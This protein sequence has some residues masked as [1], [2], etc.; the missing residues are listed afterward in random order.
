MNVENL[1]ESPTYLVEEIKDGFDNFKL[2]DTDIEIQMRPRVGTDYTNFSKRCRVLAAAEGAKYVIGQDVWL[3]HMI[4]NNKINGESI[5]PSLAG[6]NILYCAEHNIMFSGEVI[7]EI[8]SDEWVV[9]QIKKGK[10]TNGDIIIV[11]ADDDS[12]GITVSGALPKGT[13][14]TW[15]TH[16]RQEVYQK[17]VQYWVSHIDEITTINGEVNPKCAYYKIDTFD[18]Y[19][20]TINGLLFSG[21]AAKLRE[22]KL[23][24]LPVKHFIARL[25]NQGLPYDGLTAIVR[26]SRKGQFVHR[27]EVLLIVENADLGIEGYKPV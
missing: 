22:C 27:D 5:D 1:E 10:I 6:K 16:K 24:K 15:V 2:G 20:T 4:A 7:T 18:D 11:S 17:E 9:F 14:I 19:E 26:K 23:S 21:Q 3:P 13:E 25:E 8:E 12:V